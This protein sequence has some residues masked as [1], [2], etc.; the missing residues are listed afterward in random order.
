MR[1]TDTVQLIILSC[2]VKIAVIE[3]KQ[4]SRFWFV[5]LSGEDSWDG[6]SQ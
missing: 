2:C 5:I 6:S 1:E 3:K 4:E